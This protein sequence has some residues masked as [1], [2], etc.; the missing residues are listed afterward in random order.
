MTIYGSNYS[1]LV[2]CGDFMKHELIIRML[3]VK[4]LPAGGIFFS[5]CTCVMRVHARQNKLRTCIIIIW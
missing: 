4:V 3:W 1:Y 5:T 2:W